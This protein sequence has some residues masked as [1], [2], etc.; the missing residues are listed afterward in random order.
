MKPRYIIGIDSGVNTGIAIWDKQEKKFVDITT[1]MIHRAMDAVKK[2]HEA[3]ISNPI[4]VR[5][6]DARQ[7]KWFGNSGREQL[8]GAGSIKRDAG[9]WEDFLKDLGISY[10]MVAP[11]NNSTKLTSATFKQITKW[12]KSTNEHNRDAAMLVYGK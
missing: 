5:V 7:R 6:E 1:T 4:H 3:N 8:Q 11:K 12:E 2:W 9:I 10:E